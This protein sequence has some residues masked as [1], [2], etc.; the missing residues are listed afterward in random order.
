LALYVHPSSRRWPR[1]CRLPRGDL[2]YIAFRIAAVATLDDAQTIAE[3]EE[4]DS[5]EEEPIDF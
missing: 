3:L 4:S 5:P 1:C 2:T